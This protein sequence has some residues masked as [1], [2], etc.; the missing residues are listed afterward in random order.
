MNDVNAFS[1]RMKFKDLPA[2][3]SRLAA[4]Y[5]P[6]PIRHET[7]LQ[8]ATSMIDAMAGHALTPDQDDYLDLISTLVSNYEE[9]TRT[10]HAKSVTPL[11]A[12]KLLLEEAGMSA[13]ELGRLLGSR[14]LG[15]KILRG[16]RG[17]SLRHIVVLS[18]YFAVNPELF[19]PVAKRPARRAAR[20]VGRWRGAARVRIP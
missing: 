18:D 11:E 15:S 17:L 19:L 7:E 12:L 20:P 6:R 5:P 8:A 9:Q 16:Q 4:L 14:D 1:P 3:Y 13:S 10:I 2:S